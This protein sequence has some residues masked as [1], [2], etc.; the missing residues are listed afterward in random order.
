MIMSE[1]LEHL[2]NATLAK[3]LAEVDRVLRSGVRFIGTAPADE[4]LQANLTVCPCCGEIF[5]R[6]GHVQSFSQEQLLDLLRQ[7]FKDIRVRRMYF[8]DSSR[9]NWKGKMSGFFKMIQ[10]LFGLK[11]SNQNFYFEAVCL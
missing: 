5:H 4:N 3:T 11:G 1:V 7:N 10:A 2:D 9:L 8:L 6:W